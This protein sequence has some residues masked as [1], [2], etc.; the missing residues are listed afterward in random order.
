[1]EREIKSALLKLKHYVL[2]SQVIFIKSL[3]VKSQFSH[4]KGWFLQS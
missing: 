2:S 3:N 1:M 4:I